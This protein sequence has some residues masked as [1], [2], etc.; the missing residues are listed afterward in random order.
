M[1]SLLF[2]LLIIGL[3]SGADYFFD[4]AKW[5]DIEIY[6]TQDKPHWDEGGTLY[7]YIFLHYD[8]LDED[9]F[10]FRIQFFINHGAY[11]VD[12][13]IGDIVLEG[14]CEHAPRRVI[15]LLLQ[16]PRSGRQGSHEHH[17]LNFY[18]KAFR[19]SQLNYQ[20]VLYIWKLLLAN[21]LSEPEFY[22]EAYP[23]RVILRF[24]QV[25]L[26]SLLNF[27]YDNV[28]PSE[29][30]FKLILY[31]EYETYNKW[32][33]AHNILPYTFTP[34]CQMPQCDVTLFMKI[35]E[36]GFDPYTTINW[37]DWL[38]SVLD[39]RNLM[40][41]EYLL[42]TFPDQLKDSFSWIAYFSY[43]TDMFTPDMEDV[44]RYTEF[45]SKYIL[46][47]V[48]PSTLCTL[49]YAREGRAHPEL[50]RVMKEY[51]RTMSSS[52]KWV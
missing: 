27:V 13:S 19:N 43:V 31:E 1:K 14:A 9:T 3:A 7:R 49:I 15:E 20:D 16:Q 11:Q 4:R 17:K 26:L 37:R 12:S 38:Y 30:R 50:I 21:N 24:S 41:A 39:K 45:V 22:V 25:E 48:S 32:M 51:L 10:T 44:Q 35:E 47:L 28:K 5:E 8:E 46:S 36:L 23:S 29:K 42:S 2:L 40:M 52:C 6:V 33:G 34:E 18:S